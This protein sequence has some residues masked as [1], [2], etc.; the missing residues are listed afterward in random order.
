VA[1]A[2]AA[3]CREQARRLLLAKYFPA[4]QRLGL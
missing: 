4:A 1:F 3:V 2:G